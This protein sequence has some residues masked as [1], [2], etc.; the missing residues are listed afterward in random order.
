MNAR[1]Y[2]L[3]RLD[4]PTPLFQSLVSFPDLIGLEISLK[5]EGVESGCR[6]SENT[7]AYFIGWRGRANRAGFGE[8]ARGCPPL[9]PPVAGAV[10]LSPALPLCILV[11]IW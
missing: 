11:V 2:R 9:T 7:C 4:E 10:G 1:I 3:A 5:T 6:S 8:G